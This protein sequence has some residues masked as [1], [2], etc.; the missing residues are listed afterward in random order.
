LNVFKNTPKGVAT[1]EKLFETSLDLF[2]TRGFERTTM[3]DV[4]A[5]ADM[6]LGAA[7]HYFDSKDAIVAEYY[8]EIQRLHAERVRAGIAQTPALA[9]RLKLALHAK[10]DILHADRPLL[11]ALLRYTGEPSHPLSFLGA[12]TR[13]LQFRSMAVFADALGDAP[14]PEDIRALAPLLLW[15]MHMGMLLFFLYDE[16]PRQRRTRALVDRA[17]D[18]F[19]LALKVAKLPPLRPLRTRVRTM[20]DEAGLIP[21]V[22]AIDRFRVATPIRG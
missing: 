13:E 8:D 20:L 2:R 15:A 7:Y 14:M 11:G 10:L 16:S 9:D 5:A 19:V 1:R 4:A 17:V 6:S 12:G 21:P 18:L 3:R 22:A